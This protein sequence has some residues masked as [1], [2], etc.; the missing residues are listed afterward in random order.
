MYIRTYTCAH[1][2]FDYITAD[3]AHD[4]Y[5]SL[6]RGSSHLVLNQVEHVLI[7]EQA[8]EVEGPEAGCTPQGEV[9]YHHGAEVGRYIMREEVYLVNS[10]NSCPF[11]GMS[12]R[13]CMCYVTY[14]HIE[15]WGNYL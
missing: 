7:K 13:L 8:D 3:L 10:C 15:Q 12:V 2:R 9:S 5:G 4:S 1:N 14:G 6:A 11:S